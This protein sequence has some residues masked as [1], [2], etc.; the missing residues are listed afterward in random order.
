MSFRSKPRWV[1]LHHDSLSFPLQF[2]SCEA[3][4]DFLW[5]DVRNGSIKFNSV[6][7][8]FHKAFNKGKPI[9]GYKIE[10]EA[11][12]SRSTYTTCY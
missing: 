3:A 8:A 6:S 10:K 5:A 7:S 1:K 11:N 2:V 4:I 9:Y 12:Y